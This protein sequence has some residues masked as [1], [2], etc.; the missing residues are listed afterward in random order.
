MALDH[1]SLLSLLS[2]LK[3]TDLGVIPFFGSSSSESRLVG[4]ISWQEDCDYHD[5]EE[6]AA[7]AGAD[8]FEDSAG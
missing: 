8:C 7:F 6:E 4:S 5:Q 1:S 2:Q 3:D